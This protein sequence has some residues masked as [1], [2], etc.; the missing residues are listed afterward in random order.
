MGMYTFNLKLWE[1]E[2]SLGYIAKPLLCFRQTIKVK[3][4]L[5]YRSTTAKR[6]V[7]GFNW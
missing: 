4:T 1:A 6:E 5:A 3:T 7:S 2:V